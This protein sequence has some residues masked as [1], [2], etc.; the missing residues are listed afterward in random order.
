[1]IPIS[2]N[3]NSEFYRYLINP[4]HSHQSPN[5]AYN[6]H[7]GWQDV[8][9]TYNRP[10]NQYY[11]RYEPGNQGWYLTGGDHWYNSGQSL[12]VNHC[13]LFFI[14]FGFFLCK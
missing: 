7:Q 1:M 8:Y 3:P 9:A 13:L 10:I 11:N 6:K 4:S 5:Y 14:V 2:Y 12:L